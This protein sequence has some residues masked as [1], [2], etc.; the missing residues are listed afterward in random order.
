MASR[1]VALESQSRRRPVEVAS[2][3]PGVIDT[4]MQGVVRSAA[5]EDFADV[6]R[7]AR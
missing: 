7:S 5:P 2:L 4:A 3:A 6:E 1:V